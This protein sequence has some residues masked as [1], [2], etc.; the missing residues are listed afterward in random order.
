MQYAVPQFTDVED[1]L[2]GPLTLKQFFMVLGI[3]GFIFFLWSVIGTNFVFFLLAA[4]IA[5]LGVYV[6]IK[7]FNGRPFFV[8]VLP[9]AN[10]VLSPRLMVFKREPAVVSFSRKEI[11]KPIDQKAGSRTSEPTQSRLKQL[12]YLLDQKTEEEKELIIN[13]Q[14]MEAK[15]QEKSTEVPA[16]IL[17]L[18]KTPLSTFNVLLT[19]PAKLAPRLSPKPQSKPAK[20]KF[21]PS[22][23]L[24]NG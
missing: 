24:G 16:E 3:G 12:A 14:L 20:K 10:F 8:Y 23:I 6:T 1:K 19:K 11:Q 4:P 15:A 7:K 2:I 21:N 5:G 13:S 17:N 9:L 22:E 18:S